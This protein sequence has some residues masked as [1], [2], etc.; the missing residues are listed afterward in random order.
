MQNSKER[1]NQK[2]NS[3]FHVVSMTN[4]IYHKIDTEL[5]CLKSTVFAG[6][7]HSWDWLTFFTQGY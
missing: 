6:F 4:I 2:E 1:P 3:Q 7:Y 5:F